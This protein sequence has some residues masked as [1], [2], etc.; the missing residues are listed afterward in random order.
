MICQVTKGNLDIG[1]NKNQM[2]QNVMQDFC[3]SRVTEV[4]TL[5]EMDK[6]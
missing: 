6:L 5:S 3:L 4:E 1:G 2:L